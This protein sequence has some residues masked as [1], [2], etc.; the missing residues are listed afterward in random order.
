[1]TEDRLAVLRPQ[2]IVFG[3]T[4]SLYPSGAN[5]RAFDENEEFPDMP[6]M[7]IVHL[8]KQTSFSHFICSF[9]FI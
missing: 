1:M 5:L 4:R 7:G 6:K 8:T 3:T 2:A 9:H